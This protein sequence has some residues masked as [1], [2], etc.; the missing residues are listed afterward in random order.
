[1]L[2]MTPKAVESLLANKFSLAQ[3]D[4]LPSGRRRRSRH[5]PDG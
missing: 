1:M 2:I 5:K 4:L 3:M